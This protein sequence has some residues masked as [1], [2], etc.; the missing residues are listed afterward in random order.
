MRLAYKSANLKEPSYNQ[1]IKEHVPTKQFFKKEDKLCRQSPTQEVECAE[2]A[3]LIQSPSCGSRQDQ[4]EGT[5]LDS[6]S[7]SET[8]PPPCMI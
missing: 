5:D 3:F 1:D 6:T 4:R 7:T 2:G 8:F